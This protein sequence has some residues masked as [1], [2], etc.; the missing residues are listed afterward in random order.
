MAYRQRDDCPD[1]YQQG[2]YGTIEAFEQVVKIHN[3]ILASRREHNT[4]FGA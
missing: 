1:E 3:A 2:K 4:P